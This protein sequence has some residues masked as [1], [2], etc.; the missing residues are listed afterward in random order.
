M[1]PR[2]DHMSLSLNSLGG[3]LNTRQWIAHVDPGFRAWRLA[4]SC[5]WKPE[6]T[7]RGGKAIFHTFT[8]L[9]RKHRPRG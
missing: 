1:V 3:Y 4:E 8:L 6:V 5:I 9:M 7:P 2:P